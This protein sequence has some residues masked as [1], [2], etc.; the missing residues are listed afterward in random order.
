MDH[1][2]ILVAPELARTFAPARERSAPREVET[3]APTA[4]ETF[5]A[6]S[7]FAALDGIR[8]LSILAVIW[9]HT[10]AGV[11]GVAMSSNGFLGVDMFFV[12]SGF[13]IVTLILRERERTG[14]VSLKRFYVR[15]TLR[16]FPIYYLVL[17][18]VLVFVLARP[19]SGMRADF[20]RELPFHA[21][22]TTN[23]I[24]SATFLAIAWSLATEEQFYLLWPPLEKLFARYVVAILA[25]VIVLN[26]LLN[27]GVF[28]GLLASAGFPRSDYAI[29]QVTFTPICL[30][31][32]LAHLLDDP[33]GFRF[34]RAVFSSQWSLWLLTA[35]LIAACN[36]PG[37]IAGWPRLTIQLLMMAVLAGAVLDERHALSR[38]LCLRWIAW[39]GSISYGMY[40]YHHFA[41]HGADAVLRRVGLE[42]ELGLFALCTAATI[43]VAA[44]SYRWI[45][46]PLLRLRPRQ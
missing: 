35:G 27:F 8:A 14:G 13:L 44:V 46:A 38:A 23:W 30:G 36:I 42:S 7:R 18:G 26:Q 5:R 1:A 6:R 10:A 9:H 22:Y 15:R 11:G 31:V 3:P 19:Q 29:L 12:L 34:A 43:V 41:R 39:I 20:L 17:A 28:D 32:L 4:F 25:A 2:S 24:H 33:R 16:I 40:L 21:T 37:D 45:E